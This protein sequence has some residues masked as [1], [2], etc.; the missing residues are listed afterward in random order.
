MDNISPIDY[1]K[2]LAFLEDLRALFDK[3]NV[4]LESCG[5]YYGEHFVNISLGQDEI[6]WFDNMELSQINVEDIDDAIRSNKELMGAQPTS[7]TPPAPPAS[8]Q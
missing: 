2:H 8:T 3:Y 6:Y 5:S 7:D 4:S 1:R